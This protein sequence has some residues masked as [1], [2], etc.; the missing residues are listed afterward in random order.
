MTARDVI[1]DEGNMLKKTIVLFSFLMLAA[2]LFPG[3]PAKQQNGFFPVRYAC[4][5]DDWNSEFEDI[6]SRTQ[7]AMSF[8]I[9]ELKDL[10]ERCE[11]LEPSIEKLD[12]TRRKIY[13]KRL[14]M[15]RDLFA[16]ALESKMK[17]N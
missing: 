6:C 8:T 5:G 14:R 10:V 3:N 1:R 15:C 4:A 7:D 17:E 11:K 12:D 13:L 9:E 16:F 2:G